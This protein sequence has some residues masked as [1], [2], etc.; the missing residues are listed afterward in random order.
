M[1]ATQKLVKDIIGKHLESVFCC[2]PSS[3]AP[4]SYVYFP[5]TGG[6]INSPSGICINLHFDDI[7]VTVY[8]TRST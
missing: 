6:I 4:A 3:R 7:L 1:A 5:V 8:L 2:F